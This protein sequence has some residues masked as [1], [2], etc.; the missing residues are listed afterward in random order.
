MKTKFFSH[1]ALASLT[2]VTLTNCTETSSSVSDVND[3]TGTILKG[4]LS[5]RMVLDAS[6][7]YTLDGTF[8]VQDG[9]I[10]E[11]PAGTT[12]KATKGFASYLI[13]LQGGKIYAEGTAEK[14]ITFTAD[15]PSAKQG[16]WGGLIINGK[17]PISGANASNN[18]AL[19]EVD[20]NLVYGGNEV[21]DN[22]GVLSYVKILYSGARSSAE[23][24]HNGLT[25]NGVGNGTTIENLYIAEASDDAVEFFGGSVNI[26]N[27]LAVNPDDDMFDFTQG[28]TGTLNN[29]YGVWEERYVSAE[30]DPRGIEADG[31]LDGKGPDHFN[32]SNFKVSN[33]TIDVRATGEQVYMHDAIKIRRGAQ[34]VVTN[35]LVKGNGTVKDLVDVTDKKGLAHDATNISVTKAV[36]NCSNDLTSEL[37]IT[38]ENGAT[39]TVSCGATVNVAE[40]NTG[41]DVSKFGWTGYSF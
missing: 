31:N 37:V 30:E 26:T 20:N 35:A 8:M 17:A 7:T 4:S 32:Q 28:Y 10:L 40:G 9:G 13:V 24:E 41:A 1:L 27:L 29:A 21:N 19:T 33:M 14:P 15:S 5:K 22:S 34:A 39:E 23:V 36:A 16:Y 2:L 25:L 12:I 3:P 18:T 11:I 38:K 6:K